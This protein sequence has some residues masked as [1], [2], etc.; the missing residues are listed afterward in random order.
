ML[1][2]IIYNKVT[3]ELSCNKIWYT[4]LRYFYLPLIIVSLPHLS[5]MSLLTSNVTG[6]DVKCNIV[7]LEKHLIL[8]LHNMTM[9]LFTSVLSFEFASP[10]L[11]SVFFLLPGV[12][13]Q[14]PLHI[15]S[16]ISNISQS[17]VVYHF[18]VE[19]MLEVMLTQLLT[20]AE[21]VSIPSTRWKR[22]AMV[23]W[24]MTC[25]PCYQ[26]VDNYRATNSARWVI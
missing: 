8:I 22:T 4:R 3:A 15:I 19:T 2:E 1:S 16:I 20:A 14:Q 10:I 24:R 6:I 18:V 12:P 25:K 13:K 17:H 23:S 5:F 7:R 21:E 11:T 26:T 9:H